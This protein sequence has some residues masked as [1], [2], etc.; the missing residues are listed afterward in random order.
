MLIKI[1]DSNFVKRI[2]NISYDIYQSIFEENSEFNDVL[3]VDIDEKSIGEIGQFP[4]RRDVFANLVDKLENLEASVISFDIFFSEEDKQNPSKILG[5][6]NI[7]NEG[8]LDSDQS[9]ITA[10]QNSNVILPVLGDISVFDKMNNSKP[11]TNFISRGGDAENYLYNFKNKITSLEVINN[12]AK[13]IGNISYLDNQDGVLRSLPILLKIDGDIWPSLSLETL[14][15]LHK[16][17]SILIQSSESGIKTIRTKNYSFNT[18]PNAIVHI[19]Y[20]K[21]DKDKYI[22]AIDIL[23]DKISKNIIKDKIILIGSSA[24]GLFDFVKI[25]SGKV[26]PGVETHA[27]AIENIINN[28][29][30]IKNLKTDIIEIIILLIS[31]ILVLI[32]PKKVNPKLSIVFFVGLCVFLI[33]S[34]L[35]FYQF[36]YFIDV[37]Y[38]TLGSAF[39]FL[40]TLYFRYLQENEIAIENEKKQIVLKKEREIAGEVQKKLF[41]KEFEQKNILYAK[42]VPARDVSGDYYDYIKIS[43]DEFY[44]TLA[45]VSGKGVKAGILMANAAAV[46]RSMA[47]L[48]KEVST[49]ARYI[50]NQVADSSYQGMFITAVVGKY[51]IKEKKIEYINLGHEPIMVYDENFNFEYYKSTLP[52]L[53]IMAMDNDDFFQTNEISLVNKNL[54]IYTD[55]VTEGYLENNQEL[56]AKGVEKE[57]IDNKF[58]SPVAIIEHLSNILTK[59]KEPLRDDITCLIISGF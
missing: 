20:K 30:I 5:E 50:N 3:I 25:P 58:K 6:L 33:T 37:F 52:P 56:E 36:N 9:L 46:F 29:F 22:S 24:Q 28:D 59:R 2:E 57:I 4:W 39:L 27:H 31:L 19:N 8:V 47:K 15:L 13:G 44:F 45:D 34:S 43:E 35:V 32:I 23:N 51:N 11:K 26:I 18:D 12:A 38:T 10:I 54:V 53:G 40:V 14:R 7:S 21:F 49:I 1:Q 41:P 48:N 55:G 42:N 16:N 17:K